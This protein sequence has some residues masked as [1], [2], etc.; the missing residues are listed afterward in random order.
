MGMVDFATGHDTIPGRTR[1]ASRRKDRTTIMNASELIP[2]VSNEM[3]YDTAISVTPG[4][5][6]GRGTIMFD[7]SDRR[8]GETTT[9]RIVADCIDHRMP[10]L[11][12]L[13]VTDPEATFGANPLSMPV[14]TPDGY[15][16]KTADI[17]LPLLDRHFGITGHSRPLGDYARAMLILMSYVPGATLC[18]ISTFIESRVAREMG[19]SLVPDKNG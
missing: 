9:E 16:S 17:V 15:R 19:L 2:L 3:S 7:P 12:V 8:H 13:D 1:H 18:D 5:G 11:V 10:N 14:G 4:I 6:T